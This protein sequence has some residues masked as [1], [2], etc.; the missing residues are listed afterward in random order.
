M[1]DNAQDVASGSKV[2]EEHE[3]LG[4]LCGRGGRGVS[5]SVWWA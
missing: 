2:S 1:V 4:L 3:F 5:R